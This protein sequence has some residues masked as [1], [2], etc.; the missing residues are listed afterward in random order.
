MSASRSP[1]RLSA[2]LSAALVLT[3]ALSSCASSTPKSAETVRYEVSVTGGKQTLLQ[4]VSYLHSQEAGK[5]PVRV[6]AGTVQTVP[7][8]HDPEV[9]QWSQEVLVTDGER[10]E[11]VATPAGNI[12]VAS[13][14]IVRSDGS[15]LSQATSPA[16]QTVSCSAQLD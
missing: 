16:G 10:A 13:C 6:D 4:G 2:A 1:L 7:D 12:G 8:A 11:I 3:A 9:G 14:R 5:V 15:I